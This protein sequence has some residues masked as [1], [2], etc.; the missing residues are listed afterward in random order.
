MPG[1]PKKLNRAVVALGSNIRP[2]ANINAALEMLE[3]VG[4]VI[5]R[6]PIRRTAAIGPDGRLDRSQK[7]YLNCAVLLGV[8]FA[9]SELKRRLGRIERALGRVRS[10]DKFAARTIDLDIIVWNGR[11]TDADV[12]V[13]AYLRQFVHQL[14]PE[15]V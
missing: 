10:A 11:V 5:S 8:R 4:E 13:R 2:R 15:A 7:P 14:C 1:R 6:T 3:G 12:F 9:R